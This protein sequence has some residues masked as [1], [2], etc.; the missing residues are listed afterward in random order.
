MAR[1]LILKDGDLAGEELLAEGGD[2]RQRAQPEQWL[3]GGEVAWAAGAERGSGLRTGRGRGSP[4]P[5]RAARLPHC[6]LWG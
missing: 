1:I 3:G 4:L 6:R 5:G 2:A